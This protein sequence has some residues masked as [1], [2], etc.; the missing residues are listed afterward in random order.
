MG[1]SRFRAG[2]FACAFL[3]S[4]ALAS[5]AFGQAAPI[6]APP[7]I[8]TVDANG[9]DLSRGELVVGGPSIAIGNGQ[10]GLSYSRSFANTTTSGSVARESTRGTVSGG[11][12]TIGSMSDEFTY[13]KGV[14]TPVIPHGSTLTASSGVF[15]YTGADGTVA[16]FSGGFDISFESGTPIITLTKPNGEILTYTYTTVTVQVGTACNPYT[17]CWP[18]Y[19]TAGRLQ[20]V[21]SNLGWQLQVQYAGDTVTVPADLGPWLNRTKVTL[22]NLAGDWC[23][24]AATSCTFTQPVQSLTIAADQGTSAGTYT[25]TAGRATTYTA[26]SG[27]LTGVRLPGHASDDITVAYDASNRVQSV[28]KLGVTTTYAYADDTVNNVRTTTVT[29]A[30]NKQWIYKFD[31]TNLQLKSKTDP[32]SRTTSH[33]YNTSL[34]LQRVT[35]P[36]SN[37]VEY[38]YDS[39]GNVTQTKAVA[40]SGS[41]LPDSIT[42]AAY[43]ASCTNAKTCNKPTS[44]TDARGNTTDYTYDSTHGGLLTA[45]APAPTVGAVRP[46]TRLSY[47]PLQAYYKQSS[48]GSP[49]ASGQN[50]HR[51]TGA[52]AC[53]TLSSCTGAADEAKTTVS[54]GPQTAGTANNLLPVSATSGNGT[55]T[56]A[57]T[58]AVTYDNLG[59]RL[60]VDGPLA[61]TADTIRYR[62]DS[63][64][65]RIGAVSSDPDGAGSLKDRAV[66]L[67]IRSDGQV[68]KQEIGTVL[69]QSD[70][71]WAN[72]S[73]A[74]TVDVGFD[75][76]NRPVTGKLSS[77][78][79]AY[80]LTQTSYDTLGRV[81]CT[82]QRMN[83]AVY[84]SLPASACTLGT[85]GS[86]GQDR[87]NQTVFDDAG[88]TIQQKVAVGTADAATERTL[89]Y[90]LNGKLATLKDGENN[91]TT[92]EYDGHDRLSKTRYPTTPK[93]SGTSSTTDYELITYENTQS[94]TRTS[95]TVASVRNRANETVAYTYD[96]LAR[97]TSKSLPGTEPDVTIAYDLLN[98]LTSASQTGNA[99]SFTYD[100]LGRNLTQVGPQGTVTSLWDLA[101]RRTKITYPGTGLYVNY[102]YLVTGEVDKI[103]ENNA[104]SGVGVLADYAYDDLGRRTSV[105]YGNGAVQSYTFDPVSRLASLTNNLTGTTNDLTIG[106]I[107]YNPASQMQTA[108]RSNDS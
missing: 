88:Q 5:P 83:P 13:A 101:G 69:S 105:T 77:G 76:Y 58:T 10:S 85:A 20:S 27:K 33:T 21:R 32:L 45:T 53:Q 106:T 8:E 22:F 63:A 87:I 94:N 47:S 34:Q 35:A 11:S 92:Y 97:V 12:V 16:T 29:D 59:N 19:K 18:I 100:A 95:G 9:V 66:R 81:N 30:L 1:H 78:A 36:E 89:T 70:A 86:F 2:A 68:S 99:L 84:G 14:Y 54:Y 17:G 41:G 57:A 48:G 60:T 38:T 71:D 90:T 98:R 39:R 4:T 6:P 31:L 80:A 64:R 25:D 67:T 51:L 7:M 91:L 104:S 46:Q 28:T 65:Q 82:A 93:G 43:P 103:R 37:Y 74:Q 61:G 108:P 24:P 40:K 26:T 44:T 50:V 3:A 15:T 42:S 55:D 102:D 96:N 52:S 75:T 107:T 56:L 79:T 73:V 62:Y 72:F 23:D 49:A